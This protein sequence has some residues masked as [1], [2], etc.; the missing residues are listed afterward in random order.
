MIEVFNTN[1]REG[2]QANELIA[3]LQTHFP[4]SRVNFDFDDCD[5]ILRV[6]GKNI[7]SEKIMQ[8]LQA[9]DCICSVLE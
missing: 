7:S 9:K 5:K 1:A 6:E 4:G 2:S 8:M 3:L